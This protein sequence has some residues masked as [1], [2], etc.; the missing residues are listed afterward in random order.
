MNDLERAKALRRL[1]PCQGSFDA[2]EQ[3]LD[4]IRRAQKDPSPF[5]RGIA[6][7]LQE[8]AL[9]IEHMEA[10]AERSE[11]AREAR[12]RRVVRATRGRVRG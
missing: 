11:Q 1:C 5:V 7:H 12:V 10:R 2:Y 8:D 9:E 6:L 3:N 4:V